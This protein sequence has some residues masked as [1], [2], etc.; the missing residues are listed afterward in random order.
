MDLATIVG[1]ASAFGLVVIGIT[2]GGSLT[3][4][5]DPSSALI[6]IGGTI[7]ATLINYPLKEVLKVMGILKNAFLFKLNNPH[8]TIKLIV[9]MAG[10]A[11]KEGILS[12]EST[13]KEIKDPF[14][15]K[16]VAMV[17]D[18]FEWSYIKNMVEQEIK[19]ISD[20][21]NLGA[22]IFMTMGTFAPALG[23][24]GTL[25]GLVQMLQ[26]LDDPSNIGP[27]MAV[28]LIT[29]FY[30]AILANLI[31]LPIAGKL[32]RRSKEELLIKELVKEGVISIAMGEN[33]R[34][35]DQKLQS[36]LSP[37]LRKEIAA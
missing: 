32:K 35:I 5:W 18:G 30:G 33:P 25:I 11:R 9:D 4:F 36:F 3:S 1:L 34:L 7:G 12:L 16:C 26:T 15:S 23:M 17:V 6:V 2:Q 27:A 37:K 8:D 29:T 10:K 24:V 20:R 28:A 13:V 31:F 19:Y 14:L 22:E 21:H